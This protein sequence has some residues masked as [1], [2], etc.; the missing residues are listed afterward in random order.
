MR[1]LFCVDQHDKITV[2][3]SEVISFEEYFKQLTEK[4]V[5]NL[6]PKKYFTSD[7]FFSTRSEIPVFNE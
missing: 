5:L 6:S 1:L 4:T 2:L 7:L 3:H